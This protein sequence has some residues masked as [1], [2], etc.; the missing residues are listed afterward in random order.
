M[1]T[2]ASTVAFTTFSCDD[3]VVEGESYLR[4]DF[5]ISC[6][7]RMHTFFRIYAGLMILVSKLAGDA[8]YMMEIDRL[9]SGRSRGYVLYVYVAI[10]AV[11]PGRRFQVAAYVFVDIV[12]SPSLAVCVSF[13]ILFLYFLACFCLVSLYIKKKLA[14]S[15]RCDILSFSTMCPPLFLPLMF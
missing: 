9:Y 13:S 8:D 14:V 7:S 6:T 5:S 15:F 2:S 4:A 12:H 10:H 11:L 1:F 3:N